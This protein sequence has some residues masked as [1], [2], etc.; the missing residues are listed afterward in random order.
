MWYSSRTCDSWEEES[1]RGER[2]GFGMMGVLVG[3]GEV[4]DITVAI[5]C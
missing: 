3:V 5:A 1:G 2:D 4:E